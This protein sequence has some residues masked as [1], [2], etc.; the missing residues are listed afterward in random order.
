MK[1]KD[2]TREKLFLVA[3]EM[4]KVLQLDP[5]IPTDRDDKAMTKAKLEAEIKEAATDCYK[6]GD[7]VSE[8]TQAVFTALEIPFP[9]QAVDESTDAEATE[10]K[11]EKEKKKKAAGG[12]GNRSRYGHIADKV[13]GILDDLFFEGTT[14]A[15]ANEKVGAKRALG[16]LN[17]LKKD[18]GLTVEE[19][20]QG[21]EVVFKVV[22]E[23][24]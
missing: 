12:N 16:H 2:V 21:D 20:V 4:N 3:E 8:E 18:K 14:I 1:K 7:V 17:H 22:E 6:P 23:S 13:S 24:L 11:A 19:S 5:P 9:D 15:A 10:P